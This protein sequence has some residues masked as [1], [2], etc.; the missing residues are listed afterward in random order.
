MGSP[1]TGVSPFV[2]QRS[3]S[4][5]ESKEIA[6][7]RQPE[8]AGGG[9]DPPAG[10]AERV[11]ERLVLEPRIGVQPALGDH[12]APQFRPHIEQGDERGGTSELYFDVKAI[13]NEHSASF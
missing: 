3:S 13:A 11:D 8:R 4:F 5:P 12:P 2:G 9:R 6:R 10:V 1:L 7:Q